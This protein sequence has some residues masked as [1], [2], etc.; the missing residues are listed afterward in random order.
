METFD[1]IVLGAGSAGVSAALRASDQGA[2]VCII[3]QEKIGGSCIHKGLYPLKYGLALLRNNESNF[4]VNGRIDSKKLFH[5][6]TGSMQLL[7]ELWEQRLTEAGVAIKIGSGLPLS[8]GLVQVIS[9]DKTFDIA[10]KKVIIATGSSPGSSPTLPFEGDIIVPSD[11]VFKNHSIPNRVFIVGVGSYGCELASFYQMLGSKVFLSSRHARLFSDQDPEI[12][13][14][15][16]RSLKSLKV[17]LLLGKEISSYFKNN[18]LLDITLAEGIKFQTEKIILN[19]DRQGNSD[20]LE[21]DALGVR[22][23]DNKEILVNDKLETSV[24]DIFAVGSITGRRSRSGISEE[25]GKIAADNAIGKNKS[26][27]Y[28]WIPFTFFTKPEIAS[29]GCFAE[30]AHYKGFRGVEGCAKSKNLDFSFLGDIKEGFF[31]IV[32]DARSGVVIGGQ[33]VSPNASQLISLVVLAI[34][35]GMK[36]GALLSLANGKSEEIE[37]IREAA[38]LC[39]KAIK[40]QHQTM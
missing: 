40:K 22:V 39:S 37:G 23:G 3:E 15:L 17:K 1:V 29:V 26:I 34:K 13:N 38:R 10:T 31:K 36:V 16:E 35:K 11:D 9:N 32:A 6:I 7:S 5:K 30:Q 4:N 24:P 8:S 28:D 19:L 20:N 27:N 33:F 14:N 2:Q 18:E 25:E 21:C 12:L